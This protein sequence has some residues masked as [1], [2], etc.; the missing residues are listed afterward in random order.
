AVDSTSAADPQKYHLDALYYDTP[1]LDL[2][3]SRMTLRR[4][5]GGPDAGW[6]L[7]LPAI[8]GART[9]GGLPLT[10]GEPGDIPADLA[11]LVRGAARGREL[12]PVARL[13]NDRTVRHLLD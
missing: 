8:E 5:T 6:H 7:K 10:A 9:E 12:R 13:E 11:G 2:L 3:R 1:D 4:R